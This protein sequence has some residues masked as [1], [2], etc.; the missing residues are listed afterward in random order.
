MRAHTATVC[1][2]VVVASSDVQTRNRPM[3]A[4]AFVI[5]ESIKFKTKDASDATTIVEGC[6]AVRRLA[7][8]LSPSAIESGQ[9]RL[10]PQR[11]AL[12]LLRAL[13][14]WKKSGWRWGCSAVT[15]RALG[16]VCGGGVCR[17]IGSG[18]GQ[19]RFRGRG[20]SVSG[21]RLCDAR[22]FRCDD[23]CL[24]HRGGVRRRGQVRTRRTKR[25]L[26]W[27]ACGH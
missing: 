16:R 27:T 6:A 2:C 12:Q 24:H 13:S 5:S 14:R 7:V 22:R 4:V 26:A 18:W 11:M 21:L 1:S 20:G 3:P 17:G 9:G 8:K 15:Q 10:E 23:S 19:S 25:A